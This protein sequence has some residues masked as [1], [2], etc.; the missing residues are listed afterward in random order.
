MKEVIFMTGATGFLGTEVA[1]RLLSDTDAAIYALVR[2]ENEEA[3]YHR[4]RNAW[5]HQKDLYHQIGERVEPVAGDFTRPGLGLSEENQQILKA[6][7]TRV[8]HC[9]AEIGFQ[10]GWVKN[11]NTIYYVLKLILLGKLRVIPTAADMRLNL[12]PVDYVAGTLVKIGLSEEAEGKTYLTNLMTLLPYFYAGHEFHRGNT[13][14][15]CGEYLLNW[16]DFIDRVL[17]VACRKPWEI[18]RCC[19]SW[20][21]QKRSLKH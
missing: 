8:F 2:A 14:R 20:P 9:G 10:T 3:A 6:R 15:I 5:Y 12:V 16:R 11:F 4:L 21:L 18:R 7:V 17:D 13:D 1:G 19:P